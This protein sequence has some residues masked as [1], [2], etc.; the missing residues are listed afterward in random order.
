MLTGAGCGGWGMRVDRVATKTYE[1]KSDGRSEVEGL[2][3]KWLE[4]HSAN[5][6]VS[7]TCVVQYNYRNNSIT[8]NYNT[9]HNYPTPG[10]TCEG[11]SEMNQT[12]YIRRSGPSAMLLL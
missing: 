12:C 5:E 7:A 11:K 3:L 6:Q 8:C 2:W 1:N 4:H 9:I 10:C